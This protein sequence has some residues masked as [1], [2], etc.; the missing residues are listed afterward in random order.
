MSNSSVGKER[1]FW[2]RLLGHSQLLRE[3]S[4]GFKQNLEAET[5]GNWINQLEQTISEILDFC[6]LADFWIMQ[7]LMLS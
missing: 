1:A 4:Q 3:V 6:L 7:W 5:M 2:L